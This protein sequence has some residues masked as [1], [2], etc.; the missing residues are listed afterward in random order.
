MLLDG[1]A[2]NQQELRDRTKAFARR[3]VPL[4]HSL[5]NEWDIREIGKQLLRSAT[6]VAANYRACTRARSG[7]EFCSKL[8][9]VVEE[10]DE[11]QLWLELLPETYVGIEIKLHKALLGEAGEL[12]AIFRASHRT[13]KLN[14]RKKKTDKKKGHANGATCP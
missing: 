5:P 14:L 4:C 13:A 11:S 8:A 1:S 2:M 9:V 7:K 3:I 10:S 6:S 12:T